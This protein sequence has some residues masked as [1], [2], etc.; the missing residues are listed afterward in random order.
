M[1]G[2]IITSSSKEA[3]RKFWHLQTL[4][5]GEHVDE[6]VA[7]ALPPV[8]ECGQDDEEKEEVDKDDNGS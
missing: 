1:K 4:P 8:V 5:R 3:I 2:Y 6:L 7:L